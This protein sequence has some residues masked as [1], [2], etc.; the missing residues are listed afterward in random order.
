M[1][2]L[3]DRRRTKAL[4]VSK[5]TIERGEG[6][7]VSSKKTFEK[8]DAD[9]CLQNEEVAIYKE[10]YGHAS[11]NIVNINTFDGL[12]RDKGVSCVGF[13]EDGKPILTDRESI[14]VK[15]AVY[16]GKV[17]DGFMTPIYNNGRKEVLYVRGEKVTR[18]SKG[19]EALAQ[20]LGTSTDNCR[21]EI[22]GMLDRGSRKIY[23]RFLHNLCGLEQSFDLF[24]DVIVFSGESWRHPTDYNVI[25]NKVLLPNLKSEWRILTDEIRAVLEDKRNKQLQKEYGQ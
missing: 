12:D 21:K 23:V 16:G 9:I 18:E 14:K 24:T 3:G 7:T 4:N 22:Q 17:G 8:V 20:A 1:R 13:T 5:R 10:V 25:W 2:L 6:Y 15:Y 19:F 11:V